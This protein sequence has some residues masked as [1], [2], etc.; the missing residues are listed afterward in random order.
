M[1]NQF[2]IF[3][4][5]KSKAEDIA[6]V[7]IVNSGPI[8][9]PSDAY[10]YDTCFDSL[11]NISNSTAVGGILAQ[12]GANITLQAEGSSGDKVTVYKNHNYPSIVLDWTKQ[13]RFVTRARFAG[14][15]A[16]NHICYVGAGWIENDTGFGFVVEDGVFKTRTRVAA[17]EQEHIIEDWSASG[18]DYTRRLEALFT[19]GV[20]VKFYVDDVLVHTETTRIP[21]G[22]NK[23]SHVLFLCSHNTA[24]GGSLYLYLSDWH[25]WQER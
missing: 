10:L 14:G 16:L 18:F 11:D 23:T 2:L 6:D 21:S 20:D 3:G 15:A 12:S 19:P 22:S 13:R 4:V 17:L 7:Q 9:P 1:S 24:A 5:P 25:F 8:L